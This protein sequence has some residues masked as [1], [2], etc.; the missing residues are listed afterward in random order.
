MGSLHTQSANGRDV[1][2]EYRLMREA[3]ARNCVNTA[4]VHYTY[5]GGPQTDSFAVNPLG[6]ED[7][8]VY[9]RIGRGGNGG[10]VFLV[11]AVEFTSI[12]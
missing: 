10:S 4:T 8:E 1:P 7:I 9:A 3:V 2:P 12:T 5:K 11:D 6:D